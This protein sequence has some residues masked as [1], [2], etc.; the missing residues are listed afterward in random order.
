[1]HRAHPNEKPLTILGLIKL[2][3]TFWLRMVCYFGTDRVIPYL[4]PK[5]AVEALSLPTCAVVKI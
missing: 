4:P 2:S 3:G 5:Q 1:M